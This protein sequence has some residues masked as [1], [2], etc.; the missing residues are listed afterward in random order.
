MPANK[1][2][3]YFSFSTF[4]TAYFVFINLTQERYI[5]DSLLQINR[6]LKQGGRA[7]IGQLPD[8]RGS[9]DYD[10]AKE[11]YLNYCQK[12]FD[13]KKEIRPY[14]PPIKLFDKASLMEWLRKKNIPVRAVDSFNPFYRPGGP[15]TVSWRFDLVLEKR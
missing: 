9:K 10:K 3:S 2:V 13:I 12:K 6:I 5:Q 14:R 15:K 11:D 8:R 1:V 7:V 4:R